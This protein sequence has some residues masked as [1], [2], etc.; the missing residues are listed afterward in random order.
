MPVDYAEQGARAIPETEEFL[1]EIGHLATEDEIMHLQDRTITLEE[2]DFVDPGLVF[3]DNG[4]ERTLMDA[5][6]VGSR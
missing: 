1:E 6:C 4:K 2:R 5:P 3:E